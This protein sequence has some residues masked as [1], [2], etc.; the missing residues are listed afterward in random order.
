MM[1]PDTDSL[2][3]QIVLEGA[4]AEN[5][6]LR[7]AAGTAYLADGAQTVSY[8]PEGTVTNDWMGVDGG[9]FSTDGNWSSGNRPTSSTQHIITQPD[10]VCLSFPGGTAQTV[11]TNDLSDASFNDTNGLAV[12]CMKFQASAGPYEVHG[13][14]ICLWSQA[15]STDV[16]PLY[17]ASAFPTVFYAPICRTSGKL[18][19]VTG[20]TTGYGYFSFM[21]PVWSSNAD[22]YIRGDVRFGN[23]ATFKGIYFYDPIAQNPNRLTVLNGGRFY[24]KGNDSL[25]GQSGS[26]AGIID[27]RAGGSLVYDGKWI[28]N[29]KP[30]LTYIVDGRFAVS[31]TFVSAK[32]APFSGKGTVYLAGVESSTAA[33][34]AKFDGELTLEMGG[35]WKCV[36][37]DNPNTI[38]PLHVISGNLTLKAASN[39]SYGLPEGVATSTDAADR[40]I[41]I[42]K[43]A[44]L[45]IGASEHVT[46]LRDPIIGEGTLAFEPGARINVG[47][48]LYAAALPRVGWATIATVGAI[49]GTPTLPERCKMAVEDNGDGTVSLKVHFSP[50]LVVTFR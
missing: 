20:G 13:N 37:A 17:S 10:A 49:S 28:V 36:C 26:A 16:S 48:A 3:A 34:Q 39:W 43:G 29:P 35:D 40:A 32:T 8:S 47:G 50:G 46:T 14:P 33:V 41:V 1:S 15:Y 22:L 5:W 27:V 19:I 18:G 30:G 45:T 21:G 7:R 31:N 44:T 42:D 12:C 6:E 38:F 24:A 25:L 9:L 23:E 2:P 4:G 11:V